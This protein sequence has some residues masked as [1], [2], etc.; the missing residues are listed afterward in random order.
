M[1]W[2]I[3]RLSVVAREILFAGKGFD[4]FKDFRVGNRLRAGK[5]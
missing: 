1:S 5:L 4:T 2:G 3:H